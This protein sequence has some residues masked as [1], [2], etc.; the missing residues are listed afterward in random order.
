MAFVVS[1]VLLSAGLLAGMVLL[2]ELGRCLGRRR[3]ARHPG[4]KTSLGPIDGAVFGLLALLVAFTFSGAASR[5]D[6]RRQLI[7]QE[8]NAIGTAF[9][10]LDLL[11]PQDRQPLQGLFRQYL[12]ARLAFYRQAP[13]SD[14]ARAAEREF[15]R[16]Q[17]A[18]WSRSLEACGR[19]PRPQTSTLLV[20]AL[21]EM[22]D[23]TTT[24][25]AAARL[26]PPQV[27]FWMLFALAAAG[28]L[29]A[30][31]TTAEEPRR[32]WIHWLGFALIFAGTVY[33]ILDLEYPRRGL[34]R[35]DA[36][37]QVLVDL[38]AQMQ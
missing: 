27:V 9:L 14:E 29:I 31:Y 26:H 37:D 32:S 12:D 8:A 4:S 24:R 15:L 22:I 28:A 13:D 21:N 5:F 10:R 20:P 38:R 17:G 16:L 11:P 7:A 19:D 36:A 2:Q 25:A 34:I 3:L 35:L 30:G 33:V 1:T 6:V 18:L 23:L